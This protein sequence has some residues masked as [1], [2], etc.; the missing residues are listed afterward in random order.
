MTAEADHARPRKKDGWRAEKVCPRGAPGRHPHS[1]HPAGECQAPRERGLETPFRTAGPGSPLSRRALLRERT[2]GSPTL[3]AN[4]LSCT[5]VRCL[6]DSR[7]SG[8]GQGSCAD[9]VGAGDPEPERPGGLLAWSP[10]RCM[11]SAHLLTSQSLCD[12]SAK[13]EGS[14]CSPLRA[15]K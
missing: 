6:L 5:H 15:M 2:K 13:W 4:V 3:G 7:P 10:V 9:W 8:C 14:W 1:L 11:V 12:S